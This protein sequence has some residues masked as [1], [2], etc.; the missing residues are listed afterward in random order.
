M[1]L[2][3]FLRATRDRVL[4]ILNTGDVRTTL[5]NYLVV[6]FGAGLVVGCMMSIFTAG[7]ATIVAVLAGVAI[8]YAGR[9]YVSFR[10]RKITFR[11]HH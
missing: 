3:P 4:M 10:R 1:N 5:R 8:G 9:A 11:P 7:L 6:A 2:V